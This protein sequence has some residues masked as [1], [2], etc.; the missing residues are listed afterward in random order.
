LKNEK[1][2]NNTEKIGFLVQITKIEEVKQKAEKITK[3]LDLTNIIN[4]IK[5]FF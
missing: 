5:L 2:K 3:R 1:I 4:I